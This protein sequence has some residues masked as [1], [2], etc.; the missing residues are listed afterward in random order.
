MPK[1]TPNN[2]IE[3]DTNFNPIV[4]HQIRKKGFKALK[5]IPNMIGSFL[6]LLILKK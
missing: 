1:T 5:I 2:M 4:D 3:S 6:L